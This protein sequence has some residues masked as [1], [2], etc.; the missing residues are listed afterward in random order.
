MQDGAPVRLAVAAVLV[1]AALPL[2]AREI[3]GARAGD[4]DLYVLALSWSPGF[5]ATGGGSR[6]PDQCADGAGHGLIVHGLWPQYERGYPTFCSPQN[7]SPQRRD[8]AAV[9][10]VMPS[11]GLARYEWRK[12]GTCSGLPPSAYFAAIAASSERVALPDALASRQEQSS[13]PRD[14]ERALAAAN[15][16]LRP[17]MIAVECARDDGG[18]AALVEIRI[19]LTPDL[20]SFRACPPDVEAGQC[21]SPDIVVHPPR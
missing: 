3:R 21:R 8:L 6:E 19:C 15:P 13:T 2:E 20:R 17:D 10:G 11:E 14:I 4:F 18:Q 5:C 1:A 12:H 9:A 7:R 16:G